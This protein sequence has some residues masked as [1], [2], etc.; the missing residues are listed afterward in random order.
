MRERLLIHTP[1][2]TT[3]VTQ[4]TQAQAFPL[5]TVF[6]LAMLRVSL[7]GRK[8]THIKHISY[9]IANITRGFKVKI[10]WPQITRKPAWSKHYHTISLH[11]PFLCASGLWPHPDLKTLFTQRKILR[12]RD[13]WEDFSL[14]G[15]RYT[16]VE[17]T[18]LLFAGDG[19]MCARFVSGLRPSVGRGGGIGA[20]VGGWDWSVI[21]ARSGWTRG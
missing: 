21:G 14:A 13:S 2:R 5:A 7:H 19:S 8:N 20:G 10:I 12:L 18:H 6:L 17:I 9:E 3:S 4:T 16:C 15:C 11:S 1:R